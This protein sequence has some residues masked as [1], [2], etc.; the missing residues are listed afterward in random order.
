MKVGDI[1]VP[2]NPV[3]DYT[4]MPLT[5]HKEYECIHVNKYYTGED[6]V[7]VMGDNNKHFISASSNFRTKEKVHV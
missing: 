3:V 2:C 1:I 4:S 7:T 5:V 6:F